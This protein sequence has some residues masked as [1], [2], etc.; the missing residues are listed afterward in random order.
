M[1]KNWAKRQE[2]WA[3]GQEKVLCKSLVISGL[4]HASVAE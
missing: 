2:S 1:G 4:P 3:D